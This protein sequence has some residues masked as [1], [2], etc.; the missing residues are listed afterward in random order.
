MVDAGPFPPVAT[1]EWLRSHLGACAIVD[2]RFR[3]ED[4]AAGR[5]LYDEG[6]IPG[7]VSADMDRDLS[8][9]K[10]PHG[11]RHPLPDPAVLAAA[12]G[13]WGIGPDPTVIVYDD[14]MFAARCWWLLRY[15][16]HDRVAALDGGLA[17]WLALPGGWSLPKSR[18]GPAPFSRPASV[19]AWRRTWMG[20]AV[21]RHPA[22]YWA[23]AAPPNATGGARSPSTASR[24]GSLAR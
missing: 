1:V 17:A 4:P 15:L 6:H 23:T 10:G 24:A 5:R 2:C 19:P 18:P 14:R 13:R 8:G 11:G 21:E 16:G 22:R 20:C 9:P 12:F 3:L 7:A